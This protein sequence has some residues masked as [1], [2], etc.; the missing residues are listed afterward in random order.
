MRDARDKSVSDERPDARPGASSARGEA[1]LLL[2]HPALSPEGIRAT[3]QTLWP[4]GDMRHPPQGYQEASSSLFDLRAF[5][6]SHLGSRLPD[7]DPQLPG[8][9]RDWV[10]G[11]AESWSFSEVLTVGDL[12]FWAFQRARMIAWLHRRMAERRLLEHCADQGELSV[13]AVGLSD[14]QRALLRAV[15][16]AREGSIRAEIA[17]LDPPRF[18]EAETFVEMRMRKLFALLQDGWHGARLLFEDLIARRPKVIFV[19]DSNCWMRGRPDDA[20]HGRSD[21]HLEGVWREGRGRKLRL[22]YRTDRYDPEVGAM[23][24]G[25][26]APTYLRHFLFLLAQK[27]KGSWEVRKIERQWKTLRED[28]AFAEALVFENLPIGNM[29][30]GWM[31]QAI[32]RQLPLDVRTTRRETHFLRGIHPDAIL[33]SREPEDALALVSAARRLRIPTVSLQ[34]R[35]FCDWDHAYLLTPRQKPERALLADRLC[36]FSR[37]AKSFLVERG[38]CDPSHV[39]I[40]GD[41]RRDWLEERGAP[42]PAT[43]EQIRRRWG[44]EEGQRV[45]AVVCRPGQC[46]ELLDWVFEALEGRDDGFVLVHTVGGEPGEESAFYPRMGIRNGLR[47]MHCLSG[48]LFADWLRAV[49]LLISTRWP[50]TAE[51]VFLGTPVAVVKR[52]EQPDFLSDRVAP[53]T[54][55]VETDALIREAR[56]STELRSIVRHTLGQPGFRLPRD[57]RWRAFVESVYGPF[58]GQAA[59]RVMELLEGL[60]RGR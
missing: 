32:A 15:S 39:I 58:D 21:A 4:D 45:V 34:L 26:L 23:T 50:E 41:P 16:E 18:P 60:A 42:S 14:D 55:G 22:Y 20:L 2:V 13:L 19:S 30:L 40:T 5:C 1:D 46:P 47:W 8:R 31:D 10:D 12:D 9:V 43:I 49:D 25:R 44:V 27:S 35:P 11:I 7:A 38:A 53:G 33:L 59:Q 57:E 36:V 37:E 56:D 24:A 6:R 28:R 52:G 17:V 54:S 51:A 29:V 3:L 48:D